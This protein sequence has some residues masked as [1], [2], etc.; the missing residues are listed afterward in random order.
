VAHF[1]YS[2]TTPNLPSYL[3]EADLVSYIIVPQNFTVVPTKDGTVELHW[4]KHRNTGNATNDLYTEIYR[5]SDLND[6]TLLQTSAWSTNTY[7]DS[8]VKVNS[9]YYYRLRFVR[10]ESDVITNTSEYTSPLSAKVVTRLGF[11]PRDTYS[12]KFFNYLIDNLPGTRIYDHTNAAY[13]SSNKYY[14]WQTTCKILESF[15]LYVNGSLA[16]SEDEDTTALY[17]KR[18]VS[19]ILDKKHSKLTSLSDG[20]SGETIQVNSYLIYTFLM[21]YATQFL[22]LYEK[23]FQVVADKFIDYSQIYTKGFKPVV[24]DQKDISV[25]D[26]WYS[27]GSLMNLKPLRSQSTSQGI[28]KYKN[29]L[30]TSFSNQDNVGKIKGINQACDNVL[31]ITNQT[32]F[33]Y[34]KQHWFKS[35]REQ[36]LYV[37]PSGVAEG[38]DQYIGY[39]NPSSGSVSPENALEYTLNDDRFW[40][41]VWYTQ[42]SSSTTGELNVTGSSPGSPNTYLFNVKLH[43]TGVTTANDVINLFSADPVGSSLLSVE[44]SGSSPGTGTFPYISGGYDGMFLRMHSPWIGWEDTN[45]KLYNKTYQLKDT[46]ETLITDEDISN[47]SCTISEEDPSVTLLPSGQTITGT[48]SESTNWERMECNDLLI[49]RDD[50]SEGVSYFKTSIVKPSF[51]GEKRV[52]FKINMTTNLK[53]IKRALLKIFINHSSEA[54]YLRLYRIRKKYSTSKVCWN[55]RDSETVSSGYEWNNTNLEYDSASSTWVTTDW[56][57]DGAKADS[58]AVFLKEFAIPKID[59]DSPTWATMDIT[60]VIKNIYKYEVSRLDMGE[61]PEN[62]LETGFMLTAEGFSNQSIISIKGNTD[63]TLKPKIYWERLNRG[64]YQMPPNSTKY[65]Y[66]DGTTRYGRLLVKDSDR[67]PISYVKTVHEKIRQEDIKFTSDV[68]IKVSSVPTDFSSDSILYGETS[69][70]VG[71]ISSITEN[72]LYVSMDIKNF[73]SGETIRL[74]SDESVTTTISS[75]S[76]T[77]NKYVRLSRVPESTSIIRVYHTG[78]ESTPATYPSEYPMYESWE[79]EGDGIEPVF[80]SSPSGSLN[81]FASRD[82]NELNVIHLNSSDPVSDIG[83]VIVTYQYQYDYIL[84][85]RA[86]SDSDSVYRIEGCNRLGNGLYS[87]IENDYLYQ[88]DLMLPMPSTGQLVDIS[89]DTTINDYSDFNLNVLGNAIGNIRKYN[90]MVDIFKYNPEDKPYQFGHLYHSFLK[91]Y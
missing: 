19:F 45:L 34:H 41:T 59:I 69:K 9:I 6:W 7:T 3:F 88:T 25:A 33:E 13:F 76:Y 38:V 10:K 89:G 27:F 11:E 47:F 91:R 49:V 39:V 60:D 54:G 52:L 78:S 82:N 86:R 29:M 87:Q 37:I 64:F 30:K 80:L 70:A 84:L 72:T 61:D 48:F 44:N 68:Q 16:H 15:N 22:T 66:I 50:N 57:E 77:G 42:D 36:K 35:D 83:D 73:E 32:I 71:T 21:S 79:E 55:Y 18:P 12:N 62:I 24:S 51:T 67:E 2:T 63:S 5:S 46:S 14:L 90:G 43:P 53:W 40:A 85:G 74:L 23:Y 28:K 8:D 75:V 26:I 56:E 58:D 1:T 31:G 20:A 17:A 65:F 4:E 81:S